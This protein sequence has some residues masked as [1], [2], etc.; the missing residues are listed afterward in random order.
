MD[1]DPRDTPFTTWFR[2]LRADDARRAPPAHRLFD[3]AVAARKQ[4]WLRRPWALPATVA[5]MTIT[6]LLVIV[7]WTAPFASRGKPTTQ[8]E[9]WQSPTAELLHPFGEELLS[10]TP[11]LGTPITMSTEGT[12]N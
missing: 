11:R 8:L 12:K 1:R 2:E 4:G 10:Q 7:I 9:Q 6:V 5:V 3:A